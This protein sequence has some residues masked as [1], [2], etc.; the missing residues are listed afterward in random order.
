[1]VICLSMNSAR[2]ATGPDAFAALKAFYEG[3]SRPAMPADLASVG[4]YSCV[5]AFQKGEQS[6][7]PFTINFQSSVTIPGIPAQ[8]PALP[9]TPDRIVENCLAWSNFSYVRMSDFCSNETV[10]YSNTDTTFEVPLNEA[11]VPSGSPETVAARMHGR[12]ISFLRQVTET[13]VDPSTGIVTPYSSSS[14]GYCY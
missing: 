9:G 7:S 12:N 6:A 1:M 2:A 14:Y 10:E 3:A 4:K 13:T 11:D 5:I 8:G